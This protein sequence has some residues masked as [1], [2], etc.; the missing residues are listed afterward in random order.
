MDGKTRKPILPPEKAIP[1]AMVRL[2]LKYLLGQLKNMAFS[3]P[4][5]IPAKYTR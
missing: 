2:C 5:G 1:L 3:K 4:D